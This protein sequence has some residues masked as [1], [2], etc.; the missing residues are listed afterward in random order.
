MEYI[1]SPNINRDIVISR[2]LRFNHQT[3]N[4]LIQKPG[5]DDDGAGKI[6][7]PYGTDLTNIGNG[8]SSYTPV[9][10]EDLNRF[11]SFYP[12]SFS[13]NSI[14]NYFRGDNTG[15]LPLGVLV[16]TNNNEYN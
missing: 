13:N 10:P 5:E 11:T 6:V 2:R 7:I 3:N 8:G 14:F 15:N 12:T 1:G 4:L 9:I 16:T